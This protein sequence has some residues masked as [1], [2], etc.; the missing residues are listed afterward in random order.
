MDLALIQNSV[1]VTVA[2]TLLAMALGLV[3]ATGSLLL[4]PKF[5]RF[6]SIVAAIALLTPP[7]LLT[8]CWL[9]L[10]GFTGRLRSFISFNIYSLEG[11]VLLLTLN[12]WPI[13]F[14]LTSF[15]W[16]R[17]APGYFEQTPELRNLPLFRYLLFPFARPALFQAF[18]LTA[19]LS[20]TQFSIPALLQVKTFSR[21]L[22]LSFTEQFDPWRSL[23][24]AWPIFLLPVLWVLISRIPLIPWQT[25]NNSL[26]KSWLRSRINFRFHLFPLIPTCCLLLISLLP[27]FHLVA[28]GQTWREL[29]PAISTAGTPIWNSFLNAG[30]AALLAALMALLLPGTWRAAFW[31]LFLLPGVLLGILAILIFNRPAFSLL[32]P[33]SGLVFFLFALR[34]GLLA[35]EPVQAGRD[36]IARGQL[37]TAIL[38]GARFGD[39]FFRIVLPQ[40]KTELFIGGWLVFVFALWDVETLIFIVPPGGETLSLRI[41]NMLHYGHLGQ[42]NALCLIL[43]VL[44]L[45]PLLL[46]TIPKKRLA[47]LTPFLTLLPIAA[48]TGCSQGSHADTS[49]RSNLFSSVQVIGSRGTGAGQFNKPRSISVDAQNCLYVIDMTGR[50]QK[51]SPD[52]QFLQLWQ[53]PETDK[54]KAKGMCQDTNGNLVLIE[55]HYARVNHFSSNGLLLA[56]WGNPGTN[57][58]ELMFP[59]AAVANSKGELFISEFGIVERVQRFT[60]HGT[61]FINSIGQR[62]EKPGEF[63]RPEGLGID[64]QDRLY[65][66]DSCNHRIQI[67][68]PAGEFLRSYGLP[69]TAAGQLNY[70][71]DVRVDATGL[72]FVCEFG[73]SRI[74]VF[75][76]EDRTVE[77]VGGVGSNPGEL[78]NPW[79]IAL[80][81]AGNLYVADS[82]NHRVQKFVRRQPLPRARASFVSHD[83]TVETR[84]LADMK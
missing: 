56:Q 4:S 41:F 40:L 73:N 70:P 54:G 80:D 48:L 67:F 23:A 21:Q 25:T 65:V 33:S 30:C 62:G 81:A 59:R 79:S 66:A 22:W 52:G 84:L 78:N 43:L 19:I 57:K 13:T 12:L 46:Q 10:F 14:F 50:V 55:P 45:A 44:G 74:Q 24:L 32:Y 49:L 18:S 1:I 42:V 71:Y 76:S 5:S 61:Q 2:T 7:F 83:L 63:N 47:N 69:G 75:D 29:L 11:T 34:Y 6:V 31:T 36:R 64:S 82:G 77:L 16:G 17:I 37:E 60:H 53:M 58:G 35:F 27:L 9:D 39:R 28:D 68:N 20:L 3:A 38:S 8:N 15:S 72:Q 51:F 26:N